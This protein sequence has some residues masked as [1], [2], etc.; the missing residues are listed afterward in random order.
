MS[1][2]LERPDDLEGLDG[3]RSDRSSNNS[4]YVAD[5]GQEARVVTDGWLGCCMW[6]T[7]CW[8]TGCRTTARASV[9]PL[10]SVTAPPMAGMIARYWTLGPAPQL[11]MAATTRLLAAFGILAV[12]GD[13]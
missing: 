5:R 11:K 10:I 13:P 2:K 3:R 4:R 7:R 12:R 9:T 6:R 8:L 1:V